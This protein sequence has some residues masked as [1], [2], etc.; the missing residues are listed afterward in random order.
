MEFHCWLGCVS[1]FFAKA[2]LT[3]N[4]KGMELFNH[5]INIE[6]SKA[7]QSAIQ[8]IESLGG[9]IATVYHSPLHLRYMSHPEKFIVPPRPALPNDKQDIAYYTSQ[10]KRGTLEAGPVNEQGKFVLRV[11]PRKLSE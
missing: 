1:R 4:S 7:S 11:K 10:Q 9:S 2:T 5:K 8:R 6:V 3:N